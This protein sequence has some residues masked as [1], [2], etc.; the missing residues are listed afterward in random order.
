[1]NE[2]ERR[3]L[4]ERSWRQMVNQV[5]PFHNL[6]QR[7]T[8]GLKNVLSTIL[9]SFLTKEEEDEYVEEDE[10]DLLKKQLGD[11]TRAVREGFSAVQEK[12]ETVPTTTPR[13]VQTNA[14][15]EQLS[16]E[17][18]QAL[19]DRIFSTE[20]VESNLDDVE[21]D[22][23]EIADTDDAVERLRRLKDG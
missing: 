14:P 7:E 8:E 2:Q 16:V 22:S 4:F 1:M 10:L 21:I 15:I 13:M 3:L 11:L 6:T 5:G 19:N 17:D 9:D 12:I 23:D 20:G 18:I